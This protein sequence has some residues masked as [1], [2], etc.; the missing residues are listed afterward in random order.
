MKLKKTFF[1]L[2]TVITIGTV[3][4]TLITSC[5]GVSQ[6]IIN[7]M[8]STGDNSKLADNV[9]DSSFDLQSEINTA[10]TDKGATDAFKKTV[11]NKILKG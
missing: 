3:A 5:S 10:L 8:V 2:L 4:T 1:S 6:D 9:G 11:V 7:N